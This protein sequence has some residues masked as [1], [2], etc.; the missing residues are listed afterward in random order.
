MSI[1]GDRFAA[2]YFYAV[3][4]IERNALTVA[5]ATNII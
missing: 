2:S 5:I 1:A 4:C 3:R